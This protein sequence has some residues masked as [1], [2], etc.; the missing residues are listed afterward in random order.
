MSSFR[1]SG[2][3]GDLLHGLSI[4]K[5]LKGPHELYLVNRR[6]VP[7]FTRNIL[8]QERVVRPL[9]EAQPYISKVEFSEHP[10]DYD[11]TMF[12]RF[13]HVAR[14]L[15]EAQ[16]MHFNDIGNTNLAVD[17]TKPWLTT[18]KDRKPSGHVVLSR[19]SRY[20]NDKFPWKKVVEFYGDKARFVGTR[21]EHDDFCAEFGYIPYTETRT[22]LNLAEVIHNSSLFIGNQS[23]PMAIA[24]GLG[25]P[26]I[27]E[28]C[29]EVPDCIYKRDNAKY[30]FD[31]SVELPDFRSATIQVIKSKAYTHL[32]FPTEVAPPGMW[33]Y[34]G[35]PS[36]LHFD[37][38]KLLVMQQENCDK[39]EA[40]HKL[41]LY[42]VERCPQYFNSGSDAHDMTRVALANAGINPLS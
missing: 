19:T 4:L 24:I 37:Q 22:L 23:C 36:N 11:M 5:T 8:K 15:A 39:A 14:S 25:H 29:D 28:V 38:L 6:T 3:L 33:Q 7:P 20:H 31:G 10:V 16:I 21:Q 32:N 9:L 13:H 34:P 1:H 42:N 40:H 27:Q 17:L 26:F 35:L 2:D 30:C 18:G 12:R 41:M